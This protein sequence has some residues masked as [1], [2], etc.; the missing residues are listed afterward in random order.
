M[1][2]NKFLY[3]FIAALL[4]MVLGVGYYLYSSFTG[5]EKGQNEIDVNKTKILTKDSVNINQD[6]VKSYGNVDSMP[7][8]RRLNISWS[9]MNFKNKKKI[10]DD[11]QERKTE[12]VKTEIVYRQVQKNYTPERKQQT[13]IHDTVRVENK[14][15]PE[16]QDAGG[17]GIVTS[18]NSNSSRSN[19]S[20][21]TNSLGFYAAML[22]E[23]TQIK[24]GSSVVFFLLEDCTFEGTLF[25]KNSILYGKATTDGNT[26]DIRIFQ[27]MNTNNHIYST[28]RLIVYDEKY[29]RGLS[30]EGNLNEA[31]RESANQTSD[32]TSNTLTSTSV[33][34]NGV[35]IAAKALN[36]T[37]KAITRKKEPSINLFKG[38]RIFIKQE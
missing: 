9:K 8:S 20:S 4:F 33:A 13:I 21:K 17:F 16:I 7:D 6:R 11:N 23:D 38:Y 1:N 29:S 36:N 30:G 25:K 15:I 34:A 5:G 24:N 26:F 18:D 22:E 27:I 32:E 2:E 10:D 19:T 37:I 3:F 12:Q 28:S 35:G 14:S 31:V